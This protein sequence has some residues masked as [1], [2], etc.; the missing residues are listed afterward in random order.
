M[1]ADSGS[2]VV[3]PREV[4][5]EIDGLSNSEI[6][7]LPF[8]AIQLDLSGTI[9]KFNEY[10]ANLSDRRAPDAIGLNFFTDVAPCTN[11]RDFHGRFAE[12]VKSGHLHV[13][14]P[15]RFLFKPMARNVEVTLF[16][17]DPTGTVWVFVQ[18]KGPAVS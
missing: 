7:A 2:R 5:G 16:Y 13:T 14:F 18:E 10:E 17:S 15:Y 3:V 9:L 6:D 4:L 11:V 1:T 8:G 12:G